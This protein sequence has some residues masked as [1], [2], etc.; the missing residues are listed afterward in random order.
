MDRLD[1]NLKIR[2][3]WNS[4]KGN[5]IKPIKK[6]SV[7]SFT[8]HNGNKIARVGKKW[9]KP[10]GAHGNKLCKPKIGFKRPWFKRFRRFDGLKFVLIS[11]VNQ[12]RPLN[13]SLCEVYACHKTCGGK[14]RAQI[15]EYAKSKMLPLYMTKRE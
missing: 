4:I 1:V 14:K 9:R 3:Y 6:D 13:P 10:K 5:F 2:Q 12:M 15:L 8:R 11:N 7:P